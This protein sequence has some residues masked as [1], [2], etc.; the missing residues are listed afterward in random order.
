M[1]NMTARIFDIQRF[2]LF[3][4]EGIRTTVFFKGC[5]MRCKWCCNPESQ[6]F[7]PELMIKNAPECGSCGKCVNVCPAGALETDDTGVSVSRDK[8]LTCGTCEEIC[9]FD[10]IRVA[11]KEYTVDGVMDIVL[12]DRDYYDDSRGGVTLSGG[13]FSAQPEFVLA[14]MARL[15]EEKIGIMAE[16][17]GFAP[18]ESFDRLV[19]GLDRLYFDVKLMDEAEHIRHTGRSNRQ[20]LRNLVSA[21]VLTDVVVRVPMIPGVNMNR[22][23]MSDLAS[24]IEPLRISAVELLPYHRLGVSKYRELDREYFMDDVHA[25]AGEDNIRMR[26]ALREMTSKDVRFR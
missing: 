18:S 16:T 8:C 13:E 15:R 5:P 22:K 14:L 12:K 1:V 24:F 26:D 17:C 19:R 25:A 2:C 23:F 4:G 11:G 10:R 21:S 9:P 20:I 6:D 3:D 7:S